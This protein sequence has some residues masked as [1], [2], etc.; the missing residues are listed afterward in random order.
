MKHRHAVASGLAGAL[1]L[2]GVLGVLAAPAFAEPPQWFRVDV[3]NS[4]ESDI[5]VRFF[6]DGHENMGGAAMFEQDHKTPL[7]T[8]HET[9]I[10]AGNVSRPFTVQTPPDFHDSGYWVEVSRKDDPQDRT[11]AKFYRWAPKDGNGKASPIELTD[12]KGTSLRISAQAAGE[13]QKNFPDY[14]GRMRIFVTEPAAHT[15][16][17]V[18]KGRPGSATSMLGAGSAEAEDGN[19]T[20][21]FRSVPSSSKVIDI[22][23]NSNEWG[24][25]LI[26]YEDHDADNQKWRM[27]PAGPRDQYRWKADDGVEHALNGYK[28]ISVGNGQCIS[29]LGANPTKGTAVVQYGCDPN[30]SIGRVDEPNQ[31]WYSVKYSGREYLVNGASFQGPNGL[32]TLEVNQDKQL[33]VKT[34]A[35]HAGG[36]QIGS[37]RP[38][39]VVEASGRSN[40]SQ[41]TVE[42]GFTYAQPQ[43]WAVIDRTVDFSKENGGWRDLRLSDGSVTDGTTETSTLNGLQPNTD[44]WFKCY[45]PRYKDVRFNGRKPKPEVLGADGAGFWRTSD[46]KGQIVALRSKGS[47][48][49]D[50]VC[51]IHAASAKQDV[52]A[53]QITRGG[54]DDSKGKAAVYKVS[55]PPRDRIYDAVDPANPG[56]DQAV[57]DAVRIPPYLV[58]GRDVSG[59]WTKVGTVL[60][61]SAPRVDTTGHKITYGGATFYFQNES[62]QHITELR[63]SGGYTGLGWDSQVIR[64]A[65]LHEPTLTT[66]DTDDWSVRVTSNTVDTENDTVRLEANGTAQEMVNITARAASDQHVI[67][68]SEPG[69]GAV[70]DNIYYTDEY[71]RLITGMYESGGSW[72]I[73]PE[74]GA[75]VNSGAGV[76]STAGD[77][78]SHAYLSTND[79][80]AGETYVTPNLDLGLDK[81]RRKSPL[82]IVPTNPRYIFD[83]N[84]K[85]DL[86]IKNAALGTRVTPADPATT[87]GSET[88]AP[89]YRL[90]AAGATAS[91]RPFSV[92]LTRYRAITA[93]TQL[94]RSDMQQCFPTAVKINVDTDKLE[95]DPDQD[96]HEKE[97]CKAQERLSLN[98]VAGHGAQVADNVLTGR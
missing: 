36:G 40:D 60:P 45:D 59:K 87:R 27:Q 67:D 19:V 55:I 3:V 30:A 7:T 73:T 2:S 11:V 90:K 22:P 9:E 26:I 23:Q 28:I 6:Y 86:R 76:A 49:Q 69:L 35:P 38:A 88:L 25:Q 61:A 94:P 54:V 65:D 91:D 83:G 17:A 32:K 29:A 70:Y 33:V 31:V 63:V 68:P 82:T 13:D 50:G 8:G 56:V 51:D 53:R 84:L 39:L 46:S 92:A 10:D 15:D 20:Y 93:A 5:N 80:S 75:T 89:V 42:E 57:P 95:V 47:G 97:R 44:Y 74:R 52:V 72:A 16:S 4:A 41:L 98:V 43:G 18:I 77:D 85:T 48:P 71:N 64:L 1:A 66:K 12:Q 62:G 24:K 79:Q 14:K 34:T 21:K 78:P 58:E 96:T 81:P 37:P